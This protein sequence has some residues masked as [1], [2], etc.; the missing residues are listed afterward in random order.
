MTNQ[1]IYDLLNN[2]DN[3]YRPTDI[4]YQFLASVENISWESIERLPDSM[5]LLAGI[6]YLKLDN[7]NVSDISS[8]AGLSKLLVLDLS[9]TKVHDISPIMGLTNLINLNL[10][11]TQVRD[12]SS[13]SELL[14]L[15]V[16]DLSGSLVNNIDSLVKLKA[17]KILYLKNLKLNSIPEWVLG[18][19]L[20]FILD[21]ATFGKGIHIY[22]LKLYE[23]PIEIF[24]QNREL[25][26]AYYRSQ[27]KVPINECK[28]IF[29][30]DAEAGKT[31][32][33]KRLLQNGA[34]LKDFDGN[35]TPGIEITISHTKV[36][37]TDIIV[38]I[39]DFGG[40]EIQHSMHRMFLTE[41][42]VYVVFLNARQDP[43]DER[44]RYWIEN[45]K[46]FAYGAPV[47]LV[48]NKIDQND[49][50]KFNED[51]IITSYK[52]QIKGIV[53]LS[54]LI[55]PP[56]DFMNKLQGSINDIIKELP[57]A[58][59][60]VP[61]SWKDLM[62][63]VRSLPDH[64]LTVDQFKKRCESFYVSGY[65]KIHTSLANLFQ[66][67]GVSF[68]YYKDRSTADYMLLNPKWIVNAI[69]TIVTNSKEIT[70]NGIITQDDLYDV[71][72]EETVHGVPV[73]RVINDMR[74]S[75]IEVNY[76]LGVIRMFLLS[77]QLKDN[78]EFFPM[79]CD[80]NEKKS[81]LEIVSSNALHYIFRYT[82][83][84]ANVIHRLIVENQWELDYDCVWYSGA[85]FRNEN[86]RQV[87]Y[88]HS[89][90]NDLHIYV[91][92][93]VYF[94]NPNEYLTPIINDVRSIN[95]DMGLKAEELIG[96][97]NNGEEEEVSF[98]FLKANLEYGI[99]RLALSKNT[100]VIDIRK[101]LFRYIDYRPGGDEKI[102]RSIIISLTNMQNDPTFFNVDEN[103]RN[104]YVSQLLRNDG[105]NT[106]D[107][108]Q[109]G[110]SSTGKSVGSRDIV[111]RD[112]D[113]QDLYIY[114]GMILRS[115][116][117]SYINKHIDKLVNNY[118][119]QGLP[120]GFLVTY[121]EC[122]RENYEG[123]EKKYRDY[124]KGY[125]PDGYECASQ[126]INI[127]VPTNGQFL[128]CIKM[129]YEYTGC[130][131]T[132]YHIIVRI[133]P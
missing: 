19:N 9:K 44:A 133:A 47:L 24:S 80:G 64:Y 65:D 41:R 107:Q 92:S 50:P 61:K 116:D 120:Y 77:Y 31:H 76:I 127:K 84:P 62:E 132:I 21:D 86:Q 103:A 100:G 34:F 59:T 54:A 88:V 43:L 118:N 20:D 115:I 60:M 32:S 12:I 106:V 96:F 33:I 91:D 46:S 52:D 25:I 104:R 112:K 23:Q 17:L 36:E 30:G 78:S 79:L 15:T 97:M 117:T 124:I 35:S 45:I 114:E 129:D 108:S 85:V 16:L 69:Y 72:K 2:V 82:Y 40:Q 105:F 57:T 94:Y 42:T 123:F 109:G 68:C 111:I 26:S 71:L 83:L 56:D 5:A 27:V 6:T 119:P 110:I 90:S 13:V 93:I 87:S 37:D 95:S 89:I 74:Y 122:S 29:L 1:E 10:S 73:K 101:L 130:Y 128:S 49:R 4:E 53:R 67:I 38:N 11:E 51:G 58:S 55:D 121:L 125:A 28:V 75:G 113:N 81:V 98:E 70:Q 14:A 48:I 99:E 18:L 66:I 8:L 7:T 102:F 126:P 63:D 131:I 39:W 22:G 3:G